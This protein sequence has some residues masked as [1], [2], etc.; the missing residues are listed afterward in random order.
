M[1]IDFG[2][3]GAFL[4]LGLLAALLLLLCRPSRRVAILSLTMI[5]LLVSNWFSFSLPTHYAL[6]AVFLALIV[7]ETGR[8]KKI[9]FKN[10]LVA[11]GIASVLIVLAGLNGFWASRMA[12]GDYELAR[13]FFSVAKN[14]IEIA[15][16]SLQR[17]LK[18]N[19]VYADTSKSAYDLYYSLATT[20]ADTKWLEKAAETNALF[21]KVTHNSLY[22]LLNEARMWALLKDYKKAE[23]LYQRI[24][25]TK[26]INPVFYEEWA[27]MYVDAAQY[28]KAAAVYDELFAILPLDWQAPLLSK[29]AELTREQRIFWK[30]HGSFLET[31]D[32][33][34]KAY[35]ATGQVEKAAKIVEAVK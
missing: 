33:A 2:L 27:N 6:V 23:E 11:K 18:L 34:L 20:F 12:M 31:L 17:A 14:N 9:V 19:A 8:K 35:V 13:A 22:S 26:G 10:A 4:Y 30:N 28:D 16:Q 24:A 32:K 21:Q 7:A 5:A 25:E 29:G 1:W 3:G 15:D